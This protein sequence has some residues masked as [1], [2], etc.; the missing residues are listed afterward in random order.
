[1]EAVYLT[2]YAI[3]ELGA[4]PGDYLVVE[5][6]HPRAPLQVVRNFDH[7]ALVRLMG[8]DHLDRLTLVGEQPAAD[9]LPT[10]PP[11]LR[12]QRPLK[13]LRLV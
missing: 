12:L 7:H 10:V 4:L 1:M 6:G 2:H 9:P 11:S 13:A 8:A 5:P 3:P